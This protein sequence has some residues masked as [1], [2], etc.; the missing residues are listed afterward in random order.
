MFNK[1]LRI[2]L[3]IIL[4]VAC[5]TCDSYQLGHVERLLGLKNPRSLVRFK[6]DLHA[7]Y[8]MQVN[9]L[10]LILNG[11]KIDQ[12]QIID[13]REEAEIAVASFKQQSSFKNLPMSKDRDWSHEIKD[14]K[15][16]LDPFKPTICI[17]KAGGRSMKAATIF[18]K[19]PYHVMFRSIV[20]MIIS[21]TK[22]VPSR[23]ATSFL[24]EYI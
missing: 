2:A 3:C 7:V 8:E 13:V 20:A 18:G 1:F 21:V 24:C 22:F 4:S 23:Y 10:G 15:I 5:R 12:Y 11:D 19:F 16:L 6:T 14:G 9:D 17:C